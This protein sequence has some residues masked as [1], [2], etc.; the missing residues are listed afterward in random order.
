MILHGFRKKSSR[1]VVPFPL[2]RRLRVGV[3]DR[4]RRALIALVMTISSFASLVV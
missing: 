4:H 2:R 3:W 1:G